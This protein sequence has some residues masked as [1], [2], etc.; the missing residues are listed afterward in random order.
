MRGK[1]AGLLVLALLTA[2]LAGCLGTETELQDEATPVEEPEAQ[3]GEPRIE[4]DPIET[5]QDGD[6]WVAIQ[7]IN[8]TN[9]MGGAAEVTLTLRAPAGGLSAD[10]AEDRPVGELA[11]GTGYWIQLTLRARGETE[12]QARQGV[13]SM[14]LVHEDELQG[15]H[16]KLTTKVTVPEEDP[17]NVT[18]LDPESLLGSTSTSRQARIQ[19]HVP[20]GPLYHVD[21][22]TRAGGVSINGAFPDVTARADAG[23]VSLSILAWTSGTLAASTEAGGVSIDMLGGPSNGYDVTADAQAGGVSV[24][25]PNAE[26]VGEQSRTHKHVRTTGFASKAIQTTVDASTQAGGVSVSAS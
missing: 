25:I 5:H 18:E 16:L 20:Q 3:R 9:G 15:S 6:E 22:S 2:G 23:G 13:Q 8:I 24:S 7:G 4:K 1:G 14:R 17:A 26:P 10:H 12:E 21:A 19:A 11:T